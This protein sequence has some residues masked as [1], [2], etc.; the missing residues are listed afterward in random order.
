MRHSL[1]GVFLCG[2]MG[3]ATAGIVSGIVTDDTGAPLSGVPVSDGIDIVLTGDDGRYSITTEKENGYVFV[4]VPSGYEP[5]KYQGNRQQFWHQLTSPT[6]HPENA[7]FK[8]KSIND[9]AFVLLA[10]ADIQLAGRYGDVRHFNK[11]L[12]PDINETIASYKGKGIDVIALTLGDESFDKYWYKNGY[13]LPESCADM[14]KIDCPIYN[15]IGN[16]DHD[17]Y[18]AGDH[19]AARTWRRLMGPNYYSFNRG[20][21][22]FVILDDVYYMNDG[23]Y[24]GRVGRRNNEPYITPEQMDWLRKDL[25]L[26]KDRA[27]PVVVAMHIPLFIRTLPGGKPQMRLKN[28]KE[29]VGVLARFENVRILSGHTH[30][31]QSAEIDGGRIKETTYGA[32][33]GATWSWNDQCKG[34]NRSLCTNGAPAGY[35]VWEINSGKMW[36]YYKSHGHAPDY[37]FRCYD[38]NE[39]L[40]PNKKYA[41]EYCNKNDRNEILVNV[42][43]YAPGWTVEMTEN[44][45]PLDVEQVLCQDPLYIS[46]NGIREAESGPKSYKFPVKSAHMFKAVASRPDSKV[47]VRVTDEFGNVYI[48]DMER[49]KSFH[50]DMQ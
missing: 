38:L 3:T 34:S 2:V 11:F 28:G 17:P 23:A 33:C 14:E 7:D 46:I 13:A 20:G 39:I 26:I 25:S 27:T 10:L 9:S 4:S 32:V 41:E 40:I 44:G 5:V 49:P 8:L 48:Q 21:V 45:N 24:V 22:H 29:F 42:W 30:R 18:I 50:P 31:N 16:H 6:K 36:G 43:G 47:T 19:A 1:L 12:I 35:G 37:Q 15:V